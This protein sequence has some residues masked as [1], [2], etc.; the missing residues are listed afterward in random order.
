MTSELLDRCLQGRRP[1]VLV[2]GDVMCDVYLWGSVSRISPE[3]PVPVFE[4]QERQPALGGAANVA[5]N[6]QALGCDVRLLSVIGADAA[7]QEVRS[8]LDQQG[9]S[10]AWLLEDA[11]RPTTEKTR[12]IAHQQQM[13]RLDWEQRLPLSTSLSRRACDLARELLPEVD[14]VLTFVDNAQAQAHLSRRDRPGFS[15][16]TPEQV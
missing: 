10:A 1:T 5:A 2:V 16:P 7:G 4:S 8:L 3:A 15:V 12:L 6:L 13:M 9:I 11:S 14:G